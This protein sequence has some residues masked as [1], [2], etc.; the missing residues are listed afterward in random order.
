MRHPSFRSR[1]NGTSGSRWVVLIMVTLLIL[2][3]FVTLIGPSD[4]LVLLHLKEPETE[5]E[6]FLPSANGDAEKT[7]ITVDELAERVVNTRP[8]LEAFYGFPYGTT[9][10]SGKNF[11][12]FAV[13]YGF[14]V[15]FCTEGN[16]AATGPTVLSV[17][18][19]DASDKSYRLS[20]T[21]GVPL[22]VLDQ[23]FSQKI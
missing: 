19:Y 23:F 1:E 14:E 18:L 9:D 7:Y 6:F 5:P 8:R 13:E 22:E 2:F 4:V 12:Y 16:S 21:D 17:T 10:L 11:Y 20:L 15:E 3:S